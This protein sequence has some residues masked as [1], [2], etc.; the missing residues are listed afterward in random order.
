MSGSRLAEA[1]RAGIRF[2]D[3]PNLVRDRI[4]LVTFAAKGDLIVELRDGRNGSRIKDA[5]E[6]I[7]TRAHKI[8]LMVF[9]SRRLS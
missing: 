8:S 9:V 3:E 6:D 4:A 7:Q 5:I 2:V 1:K